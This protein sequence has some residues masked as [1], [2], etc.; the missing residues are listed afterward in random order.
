[1]VSSTVRLRY[2]RLSEMLAMFNQTAE[3]MKVKTK[4]IMCKTN[5]DFRDRV[6]QNILDD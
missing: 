3:T 6:M 5:S 2:A 4:N 1:M